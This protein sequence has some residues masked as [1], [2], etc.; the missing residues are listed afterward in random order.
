M[1]RFLFG[2]LVALGLAVTAAPAKADCYFQS[3]VCRSMTWVHT[4]RNRCWSFNSYVNPLPCIS[5]CGGGGGYSSAA[6]WPGAVGHAP[7]GYAPYGYAP[8]AVAAAPAAAAPAAAT[9]ATQPSFRAPQPTPATNNSTGLQQAGYAYY[10]QTNAAGYGYNAGYNYGA[11]YGYGY[12]SYA[13]APNY[14][15]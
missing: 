7:Y 8:G 15:Y 2:G 12:Y 3:N 9:P 10:G 11:G 4:C 6:P 14:W 13:Q 5:T 1:K